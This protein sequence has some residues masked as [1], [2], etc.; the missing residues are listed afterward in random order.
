[1][2]AEPPFDPGV[3]EIVAL[4]LPATADK[5]VGAAGAVGGG[6]GGGEG[7]DTTQRRV[8]ARGG[9]G[10]D[11]AGAF[12]W[13]DPTCISPAVPLIACVAFT[14]NQKWIRSLMPELTAGNM[15][16]PPDMYGAAHSLISLVST[17]LRLLIS[18]YTLF[19]G[20]G[21]TSCSPEGI[22]TRIWY[23]ALHQLDTSV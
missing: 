16:Y 8:V 10:H 22:S 19:V 12:V 7:D 17:L 6:S 15:A 18:Q 20:V 9:F 2:I 4:A 21:L 3:N 11:W 1:M 13:M 14:G 23:V 5:P